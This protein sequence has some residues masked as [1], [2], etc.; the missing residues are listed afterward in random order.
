M[1]IVVHKEVDVP[2]PPARA[3]E[4]FTRD[5]G[6]WWPLGTHGVFGARATVT[7]DAERIVERLDE[8]ESTWAEVIDWDPPRGFRV[9]W[10]PGHPGDRSTDLRVAFRPHG[11]GCRVVLDHSGWERIG[12]AEASAS[13]ETGWDVVLGEYLRECGSPVAG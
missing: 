6:R 11:A 1:D 7:F 3:F 10:H 4:L 8:R 5:I 2:V 12:H 13:Y 9:A